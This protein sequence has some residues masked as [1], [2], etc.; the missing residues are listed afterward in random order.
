[1]A[2]KKQTMEWG[3]YLN[4]RL[5]KEQLEQFDVWHKELGDDVWDL[6]LQLLADGMKFGLTY[7]P[8]IDTYTCT[9]TNSARCPCGVSSLYVLSGYAQ[10][11]Y[12]AVAVVIFK[13]F[14]VLGGT[15]EHYRPSRPVHDK[16]G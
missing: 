14:Q 7:D 5:S 12:Q 8:D 4:V 3:G 13:H 1:M 6:F 16:I 10:T 2:R 11:W 9:L 15:W